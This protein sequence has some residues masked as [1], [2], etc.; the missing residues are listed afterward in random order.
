MSANP[1]LRAGFARW[2]PRAVPLVL[3]LMG[4]YILLDLASDLR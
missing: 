3:I 4:L 1:A 2:G